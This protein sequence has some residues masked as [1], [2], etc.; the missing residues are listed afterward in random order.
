VRSP[1]PAEHGAIT[2]EWII[3]LPALVLVAAALTGGLGAGLSLQRLHHLA[4]DHARVLSLGGDPAGL[5]SLAPDATVTITYQPD[6]VCVH[7]EDF[8][9][10]GWWALAPLPLRT[11]AC[12]L[13]PIPADGQ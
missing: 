4:S 10:S 6:L 3:T 2:A 5:T 7:Y 13:N 12:A 11:H 8:V 9:G 1:S